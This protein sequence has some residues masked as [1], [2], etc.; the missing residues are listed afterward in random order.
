MYFTLNVWKYSHPTPFR[1]QLRINP[2]VFDA[3][4]SV[5]EAHP[6]FHNRSNNEQMPVQEQLTITLYRLG[7]DGNSSNVTDVG[8]W[9]GKGHGTIDLVTRRVLIAMT[10]KAFR[11]M[12][13][14]PPTEAEKEHSRQWV[15]DVTCPAW[16]GGWCGVDGSCVPLF[17]RPAHFGNTW[18]DR[19]SRY[20]TNVQV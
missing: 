7:H 11:D 16:R 18:Y 20:S 17:G 3:L 2:E 1:G 4:V 15:E 6:I 19:K 5:L 9:S 13:L 14:Y 12:T 8:L 10:D